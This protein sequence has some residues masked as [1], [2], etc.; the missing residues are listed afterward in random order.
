MKILL[1]ILITIIPFILIKKRK[2][3]LISSKIAKKMISN[4]KIDKIIDVRS[5]EE[6]NK[7]HHPY[8]MNIP[9]KELKKYNLNSFDKHKNMLIYCR[10]G[11][12]ALKAIKYLNKKCFKNIYYINKT[13]KSLL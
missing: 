6:W 13:Y 5:K 10:S 4:R 11:R 12:R 2:T 1:L 7:G 8:A 9:I 3:K